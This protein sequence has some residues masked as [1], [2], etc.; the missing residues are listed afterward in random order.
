MRENF[1]KQWDWLEMSKDAMQL[2]NAFP[3]LFP[4]RNRRVGGGGCDGGCA[5]TNMAVVV[6]LVAVTG[7][8][9]SQS[10]LV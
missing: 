9:R 7:R 1:I 10:I 4:L 5:V 3:N 2:L 6:G 8:M